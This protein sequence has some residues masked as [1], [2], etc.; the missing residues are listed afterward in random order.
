MGSSQ[1]RA[2]THVPCIGRRVVNH[3]TTRE[4]LQQVLISY[5]FYFYKFIYLLI[6]FGCAGSLL[7]CAGF[8]S[9]CRE[10]ELLFIVVHSLLIVVASLVAEHGLSAHGLASVV[11]ARGL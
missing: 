5:L 11:V 8:F 9:S 6:Y 3:C 1:T 4:A 10:R 7:L 2:R